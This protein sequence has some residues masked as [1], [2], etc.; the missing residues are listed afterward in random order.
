[1]PSSSVSSG[2]SKLTLD[3]KSK[4]KAKQPVADSWEDEDSASDSETPAPPTVNS[5]AQAPPPTP[6]SPTHQSSGTTRQWASMGTDAGLGPGPG[7]RSP[8]SPDAERR[9]PEKTDAV[10]RRLIAGALGVKAPKMT[11]EQRAY[12]KSVREQ[13]RK[14]RDAEKEREKRAQEEAERAKAA[15]WED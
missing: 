12:E 15:V 4:P 2:L 1:M 3:N 10:A 13:E 7:P 8:L 11:E 5:G 9:R 14:R 6:I